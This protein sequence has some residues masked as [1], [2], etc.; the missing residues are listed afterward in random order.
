VDVA[1]GVFFP[2]GAMGAAGDDVSGLAWDAGVLYGYAK[3]G[4][5]ED[6]LVM[7]DTATGGATLVGPTGIVSDASVGG[8]AFDATGALFVTDG[9]GMFT[10]DTATGAATLVGDTSL[11]G[12]S[13]MAYIPAPASVLALGVLARRRRR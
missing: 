5:D 4:L 11:S 9:A 8:A 13:G 3:N 12:I 6:T 10:V 1:T 2:V 7:I